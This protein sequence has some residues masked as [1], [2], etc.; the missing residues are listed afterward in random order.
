MIVNLDVDGYTKT[1]NQRKT[2]RKM[3]KTAT[4]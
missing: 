4:Y 1:R 3:H 2:L